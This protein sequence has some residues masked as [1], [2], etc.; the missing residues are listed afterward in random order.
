VPESA[1][2]LAVRGIETFN[3]EFVAGKTGIS[4]ETRALWV[5]EPVIVPFRAALEGTQY[6]GPTALEEFGADTRESWESIRI[7][8]EEIRELD[9]QRVLVVGKLI[10]RGRETGVETSAPIVN[11]FVISEGRIAESRYFGSERDALA[12]AGP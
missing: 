5:A 2:A 9:P 10:G 8:P 6:R 7:E 4:A 3:R 11:L 1:K 12:E